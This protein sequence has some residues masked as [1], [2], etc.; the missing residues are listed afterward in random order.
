M[1]VKIN[2]EIRNYTESIMFGLSLRQCIYSI[3]ACI[4]AMIVYFSCIHRFGTEITSWLCML[5]AVPFA[6]LG[7]VTYQEMTAEKI[8]SVAIRSLLLSSRKLISRPTNVYYLSVKDYI[9]KNIKED[10]KHDKKSIKVKK[11]K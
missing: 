8:V 6:A 9:E 2:K 10:M 11:A 5:G 1:E 4:V 3:L 7:F